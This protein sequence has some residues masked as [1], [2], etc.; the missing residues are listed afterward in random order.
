MRRDDGPAE[1]DL[2]QFGWK[3]GTL[4]PRG[5]SRMQET[6]GGR[7]PME[8][9]AALGRHRSRFRPPQSIWRGPAPLEDPASEIYTA[10][11]SAL[12]DWAL[13]PPENRS[14]LEE[15]V[16]SRTQIL[17]VHPFSRG[18]PKDPG[19]P[20]CNVT[21]AR[22]KCCCGWRGGASNLHPTTR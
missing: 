5:R 11:P 6:E 15:R 17:P 8:D 19:P 21:L 20:D 9:A 13:R 22:V 12:D 4:R 1:S 7:L 3:E 2:H 18:L 16:S 10:L 14:F